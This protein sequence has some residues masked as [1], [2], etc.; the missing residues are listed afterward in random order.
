MKL[1][2]NKFEQKVLHSQREEEVWWV[3]YKYDDYCSIIWARVW[4]I[5]VLYEFGSLCDEAEVAFNIEMRNH[6]VHRYDMWLRFFLN[7]IRLGPWRHRIIRVPI[8]PNCWV[9]RN[10]MILK[11]ANPW[12]QPWET[13][14][15]VF[16]KEV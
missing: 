2:Q 14:D 7:K 6:Y 16:F 15:C 8:S 13:V 5:S 9:I 1:L 4:G 10:T 3:F 12:Q 11:S